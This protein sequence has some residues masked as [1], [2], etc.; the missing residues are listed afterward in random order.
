MAETLSSLPCFVGSP[1]PRGTHP[2]KNADWRAGSDFVLSYRADDQAWTFPVK[3]L[4]Y[5]EIVNDLF[6]SKPVL[7]SY[8]RPLC[9]SG[10]VFSHALDD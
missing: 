7:I 1:V 5:H 6:A 9:D 3:I 10:I 4:N 2:P 8:C